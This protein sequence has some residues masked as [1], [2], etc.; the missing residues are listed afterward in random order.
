MEVYLKIIPIVFYA[1]KLNSWR[2]CL[3]KN[4][5]KIFLY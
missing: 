4:V 3:E 2:D 5:P 1:S